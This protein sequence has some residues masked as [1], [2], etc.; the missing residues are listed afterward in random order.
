MLILRRNLTIKSQADQ[1]ALPKSNKITTCIRPRRILTTKAIAIVNPSY[2]LIRGRI[3]LVL[4]K[5]MTK[6]IA[7][8]APYLL[9]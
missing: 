8:I 4:I 9:A 5:V 6:G 3:V 1:K 7:K 2:Y